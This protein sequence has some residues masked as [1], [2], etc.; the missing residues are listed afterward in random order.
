MNTPSSHQADFYSQGGEDFLLS[1]LFPSMTEGVFVE[2][3]CIDG[4]RFSNTYHFEKKGWTGICVEAHAGYIDLLRKNRPNSIIVHA[5]AGEQDQDNVSFFAN[6]RG[7][8]STLEKHREKQF[9]ENYG[10]YFTGFETQQV[11]ML[12]LGTIF[13]RCNVGHI[14]ILSLDIEGYEVQAL[15]GINFDRI[16]PTVMV[17][18]CD[19]DEDRKA[20]EAILFPHGYHYITRLCCNL[21]YSQDPSHREIIHNKTFRNIPVTHTQH[22]LDQGGDT[23]HRI[24]VSTREKE[25][26]F[27]KKASRAL[28]SLLSGR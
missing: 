21:F 15:K 10:E 17:I 7:S 19:S 18:E 14:D 11:P 5:A 26:D 16:K 23:H 12:T 8:L 24:K 13:E 9:S 2:V 4:K 3:G 1:L 25:D 6:S 28:K 27:F 20:V 22:P